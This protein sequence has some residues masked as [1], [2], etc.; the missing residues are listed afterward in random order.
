[1]LKGHALFLG[2]PSR[3]ENH[4]PTYCWVANSLAFPV[5]FPLGAR[6]TGPG[7]RAAGRRFVR[8]LPTTVTSTSA[9]NE[10]GNE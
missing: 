9:A 8:L 1:M 6:R 3:V 2:V 10:R 5:T 7:V 4:L